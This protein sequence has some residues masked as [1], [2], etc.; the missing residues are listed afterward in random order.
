MPDGPEGV[1]HDADV[2]IRAEVAGNLLEVIETGAGR[3]RAI[4]DLIGGAQQSVKLLF[5]MFNPDDAGERVRDALVE[6]ARRG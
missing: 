6:A 4:L 1:A 2:A 3:L 5:Y